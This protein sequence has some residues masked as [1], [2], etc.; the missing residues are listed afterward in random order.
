M[1]NSFDHKAFLAAVVRQD[2]EGLREFFVNEAVINWHDSNESLNVDEYIRAN[3]EYPGEW[4]GVCER[5][6]HFGDL[7]VTASKIF[8]DE[9]AF[10]VV[11]FIKLTQCG[12]ISQLDEYFAAIEEVPRW[13]KDMKIGCPIKKGDLK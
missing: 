4:S 2:A 1:I 6:E 8:S 11:S 9:L 3:C 12:K 10:Y 13:R 7:V 5:V